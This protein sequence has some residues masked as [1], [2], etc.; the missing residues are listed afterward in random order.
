MHVGTKVVA[1]AERIFRN[2]A[3][4]D[5]QVFSQYARH[6]DKYRFEKIFRKLVESIISDSVNSEMAEEHDK[7]F[8][9]RTDAEKM[10][11]KSCRQ[12]AKNDLKTLQKRIA[13][14]SNGGR[15]TKEQQ[16]AQIENFTNTFGKTAGKNEVV[17]TPDFTL[18]KNEYFD[19]YR[20]TYPPEL[21]QSMESWLKKSFMGRN[22]EYAWIG[23][24]MQNFNQRKTGKVL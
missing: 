7:M 9:P 23:K 19:S 15:P 8:E 3:R 12:L 2:Y 21:I 1:M 13:G 16:Q 22:V 24:Q 14:G 6:I 20:K 17:I 10:F 5:I 4:F 18:P 11:W